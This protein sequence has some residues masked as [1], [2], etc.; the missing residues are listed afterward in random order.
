MGW[1]FVAPMSQTGRQTESEGWKLELGQI[2][3]EMWESNES[4]Y[5]EI[6]CDFYPLTFL[7]SKAQRKTKTAQSLC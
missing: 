3:L 6:H 5:F 1:V 7:L 2:W 4:K